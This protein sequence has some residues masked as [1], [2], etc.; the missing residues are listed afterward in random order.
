M[1][2]FSLVVATVDRRDQLASLFKSLRAQS[3][4]DFEIIVVDQNPKGFIDDIVREFADFL[5]INHVREGRRGVSRARNIGLSLATGDVITFPDDDC[6]YSP[7]LL[8]EVTAAFAANPHLSGVSVA[9]RDKNFEGR[10]ARFSG[11]RGE[12]TKL[13]I[14]RRCIEFGIFVKRTALGDSQFDEL[15]GVGA[16]TPWWSDEGPD[17]LIPLLRRGHQIGYFPHIVIFHPNPVKVYDERAI[18]R[19]Y[20]YGCGRGHFLRKHTYPIWFV[21]YVW[22]LYAAGILIGLLQAK[23]GKC[24]YYLVGLKGRIRGYF[25]SSTHLTP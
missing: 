15:M 22:A 2:A 17:L 23:P 14:L 7:N 1:P 21:L 4:D 6:E 19:S 10:I 24:K 18:L 11:K 20:R 16:E 12:I 9:S 8:C 3:I 5:R 13:N 25:S